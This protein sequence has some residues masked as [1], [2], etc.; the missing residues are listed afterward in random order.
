MLCLALARCLHLRSGL[1]LNAFQFFLREFGEICELL[2]LD[3]VIEPLEGK[4]VSLVFLCLVVFGR[5]FVWWKMF[6]IRVCDLV[7]YDEHEIAYR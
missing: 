1:S 2:R 4:R 7:Q 6:A 3:R 5:N